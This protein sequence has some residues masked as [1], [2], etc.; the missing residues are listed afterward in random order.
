MA[1]D[2]VE[3]FYVPAVVDTPDGYCS[4]TWKAWRYKGD[5]IQWRVLSLLPTLCDGVTMQSKHFRTHNLLT[6]RFVGWVAWLPRVGATLEEHLL[7]SLTPRIHRGDMR[8]FRSRA[9]RQRR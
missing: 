3:A 8:R 6:T 1:A 7:L 4:E 2:D 9:G 5:V